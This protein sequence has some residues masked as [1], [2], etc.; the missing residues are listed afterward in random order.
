MNTK[1]SNTLDEI[2]KRFAELKTSVES[3]RTKNETL[4]TEINQLKELVKQHEA[5]IAELQDQ[6]KAKDEELASMIEQQTSQQTETLVN[7]DEEIDFLVR[8]IDQCI[9]QIKTNL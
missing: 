8:E 9:R 7:K 3:E 5:G 4:T 2:R 1:I 6:L